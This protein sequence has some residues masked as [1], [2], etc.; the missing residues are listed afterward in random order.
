MSDFAATTPF[1]LVRRLAAA[2][3]ESPSLY[4]LIA[5]TAEIETVQADVAAEV[6]VQIGDTPRCLATAEIHTENLEDAFRSANPWP[7]VLVTLDRWI[8]KLIDSLDRNIVLAT[9]AGAVFLLTNEEIANRILA[10]APN[11]RN[12]L[13]DVVSIAPDEAIGGA[14]D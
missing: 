3:R 8:P 7:V 13:T 12:R 10:A 9:S 6:E 11:L 14:P 5:D 2:G 4:L 1:Q